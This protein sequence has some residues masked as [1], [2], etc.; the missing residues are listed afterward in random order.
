MA[1]GTSSRPLVGKFVQLYFLVLSYTTGAFQENPVLHV[2]WGQ[3]G[4]GGGAS[5]APQPAVGACPVLGTSATRRPS[6]LRGTTG[7]GSACVTAAVQGERWDV[8]SISRSRRSHRCYVPCVMSL[9]KWW[10]RRLQA[11]GFSSV[12]HNQPESGSASGVWRGRRINENIARARGRMASSLK[13]KETAA[14]ATARVEAP[15]SRDPPVPGTNT[16][17]SHLRGVPGQSHAETE[18]G[19]WAPGLGG[20]AGS[21]CLT[22]RES[23][24]AGC[25]ELRRP[26]LRDSVGVPQH[27]AVWLRDS[28]GV[29]PTLGRAA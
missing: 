3:V 5:G 24:F 25:R 9:G 1:H 16:A 10:K 6:F 14:R 4:T 19:R 22:S 13:R 20:E 8:D 28:V 15:R 26:R 7:L 23:R 29:S 17:R 21:W 12:I 18:S 27:W 11:R 2:A